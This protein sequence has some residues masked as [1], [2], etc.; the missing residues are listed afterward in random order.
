[1]G[2]PTPY[3]RMSI[4]KFQK[5]QEQL[6]QRILLWGDLSQGGKEVMIKGVAQ[7]MATYIM[8]VLSCLFLFVMT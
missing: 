1:L 3:G 8:G 2:L 4:G 5:L 6:A 7:S